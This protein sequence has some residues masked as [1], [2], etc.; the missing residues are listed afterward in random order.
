MG[1]QVGGKDD[2]QERVWSGVREA[3]VLGGEL[4]NALDDVWNDARNRMIGGIAGMF[5]GGVGGAIAMV[6][7]GGELGVA[8]GATG[9][10]V[11]TVGAFFV[12]GTKRAIANGWKAECESVGGRVKI[13]LKKGVQ[14]EVEEVSM[15][16]EM[17]VKPT[18]GYLEQEMNLVEMRTVECSE[19]MNKNNEVRNEIIDE[20]ESLM[21]FSGGWRSEKK[22]V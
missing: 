8:G 4:R 12:E 13:L 14:N 22:I 6:G 5:V 19:L 1:K 20:S 16:M 10:G 15:M 11:M 7:V 18:M 21:N 17:Q 3:D 9:L 2:I